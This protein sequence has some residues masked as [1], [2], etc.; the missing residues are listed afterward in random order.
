[1]TTTIVEI[2]VPMLP[3][4]DLP[5]G[6]S[7]YPWIDQVEDFLADLEDEGG[8]E[9]HDEGEEYADAYVL[10][11]LPVVGGAAAGFVGERIRDRRKRRGR[12]TTRRPVQP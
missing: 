12:G 9:V 6:S 11:L 4:P 3:T 1:M 7:P 10:A 2:H 8:I 5:D